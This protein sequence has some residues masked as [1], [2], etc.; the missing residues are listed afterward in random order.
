MHHQCASRFT[1]IC[2][3]QRNRAN[4]KFVRLV[5]NIETFGGGQFGQRRKIVACCLDAGIGR[6]RFRRDHNRR[7]YGISRGFRW[8]FENGQKQDGFGRRAGIVLE[9][10]GGTMQT[11]ARAAMLDGVRWA[12]E[13]F[14]QCLLSAPLATEARKY[15]GERGLED[16]TVRGYGLGYSPRS[17]PKS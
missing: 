16:E 1:K 14:H 7:I 5:G 17:G 12:A 8:P 9:N 2:S 10:R 4:S 11:G 6:K 15:L 3:H 13:Q